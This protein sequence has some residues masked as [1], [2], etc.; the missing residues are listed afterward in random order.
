MTNLPNFYLIGAAKAGTSALHAYLQQ[1]PQIFMSSLKEPSFFALEG[2]SQPWFFRP[3]GSAVPV[4]TVHDMDSYAALFSGAAGKSVV[5]DA[6]TLYLFSKQVA[7]RLH[8]HVPGA[9]IVAVLRHPADRAYSHYLYFRF[10]GHEPLESFA[11]AFWAE[12]DRIARGLGA[13]WCYRSMG[14]YAEQ[15]ARYLTLFPGEQ[16]KIFLYEDWRREPQQVVA[17]LFRFLGVDDRFVPD[18]SVEH[19]MGGVPRSG[20]LRR[21][22]EHRTSF[23]RRLGRALVPVSLRPRIEWLL[24]R[25]NSLRPPMSPEVRRELTAIYRADIVALER[26]IDRDLSRWLDDGR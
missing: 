25:W 11:E 8:F 26:L 2:V 12:D 13:L 15:L 23:T 21:A 20:G 10:R 5:G 1:H 22:M 6:S 3:D 24:D 18:M 4:N 16:I 19:R 9:K 17:E 7:P 14:F